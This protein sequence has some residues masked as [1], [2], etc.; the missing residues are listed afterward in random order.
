MSRHKG[1]GASHNAQ[2]ARGTPFAVVTPTLL[3]VLLKWGITRMAARYRVC[4]VTGNSPLES[5]SI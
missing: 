5:R 3:G 1:Q 4:Y 2:A